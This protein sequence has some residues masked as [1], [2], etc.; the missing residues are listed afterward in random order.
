MADTTSI[1]VHKFHVLVS[2]TKSQGISLG[3]LNALNEGLE[4]A[5]IEPKKVVRPVTPVQESVEEQAPLDRL[6]AGKKKFEDWLKAAEQMKKILGKKLQKRQVRVPVA[7]S[8]VVRDAIRRVFAT[9]SDTITYEMFQK[10]L[11][12]RSDLLQKEREKDYGTNVSTD[13]DG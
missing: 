1:V 10:A 4:V 2:S 13:S 6:I 12:I 3:D 5:R 9:D 8:L 11:E 7:K